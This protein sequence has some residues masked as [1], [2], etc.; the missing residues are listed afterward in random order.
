MRD[1]LG[2]VAASRRVPLDD[3]QVAGWPDWEHVNT[4]VDWMTPI[5]CGWVA[6]TPADRPRHLN[7]HFDRRERI[8]LIIDSGGVLVRRPLFNV[9]GDVDMTSL[10]PIWMDGAEAYRLYGLDNDFFSDDVVRVRGRL[11]AGSPID[12]E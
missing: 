10:L 1:S 6:A 7:V 8:L 9:G 12:L 3:R 11:L 2:L 5:V 4:M